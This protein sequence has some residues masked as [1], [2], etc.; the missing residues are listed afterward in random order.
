MNSFAIIIFSSLRQQ[1]RQIDMKVFAQPWEQQVNHR[2]NS[3]MTC[4]TE[5][6][7]QEALRISGILFIG[8]TK[9]IF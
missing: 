7:F 1:N 2:I 8:T 3:N 5:R 9:Y 4:P 6:N